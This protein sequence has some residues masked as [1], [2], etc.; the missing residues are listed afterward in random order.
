MRT[1]VTLATPELLEQFYGAPPARSI[2]AV[3]AVKDDQVIGVAGVYP[4][5]RHGRQIMFSDLTDTLRAE[6]RAIVKGYRMVLERLVRPGIPV[7][8]LVDND[9]KGADVLLQHI[10]FRHIARGIYQWQH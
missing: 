2:R 4:D 7:Q 10:G 1:T 9:I 3:V 8:T 5:P 6:K